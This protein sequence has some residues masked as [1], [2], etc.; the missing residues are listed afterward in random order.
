M[1]S[2]WLS[3]QFLYCS[4]VWSTLVRFLLVSCGVKLSFG[5][6][7]LGSYYKTLES[8]APRTELWLA[9]AKYLQSVCQYVQF[10]RY[11]RCSILVS[12]PT[13]SAPVPVTRS[14]VGFTPPGP[15]VWLRLTA[16]CVHSRGGTK[17]RRRKI[18]SSAQIWR[19]ALVAHR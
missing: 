7:S 8:F 5:E 17:R 3:A 1:A 13:W 19:A 9:E 10:V 2:A 11:V 4:R 12:A 15:V 16:G 18:I 6:Q 14:P